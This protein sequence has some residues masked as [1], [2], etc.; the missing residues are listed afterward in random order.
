MRRVVITGMGIISSIGNNVTEVEA[1][2]RAGKSGIV[3]APDYA[4][5]GFRCRVHG[6]PNIVL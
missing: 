3:F 1:S 6:A 2:L 5:H 4:E